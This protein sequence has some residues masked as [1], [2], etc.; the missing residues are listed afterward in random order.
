[1]LYQRSI[2]AARI[3]ALMFVAAV[4]MSLSGIMFLLVANYM[5]KHIAHDR[6]LSE[7]KDEFQK[8]RHP[9]DTSSVAFE[10]RVERPTGNGNNCFYFVGEL[11][12]YW[13][14]RSSIEAFYAVQEGVELE[15]VENGKLSER[16]P[17]GLDS[18]SNWSRS[19]ANSN[20][21]LYVVFTL[22]DDFH[23]FASFDLR[24]H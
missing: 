9:P 2:K 8:L 11:R 3:L 19:S 6:Q 4:C 22:N 16:V 1:M 24:C 20:D 7:Y 18:L 5:A 13:G 10:S 12:R 14:T 23:E 17:Y 21:N 15:F